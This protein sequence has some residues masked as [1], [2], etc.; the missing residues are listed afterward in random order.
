MKSTIWE[1]PPSTQCRIGVAAP[2]PAR[3][4][5]PMRFV[6]PP[7]GAIPPPPKFAPKP[8]P[9]QSADTG[10]QRPNYAYMEMPKE[11]VGTLDNLFGLKSAPLVKLK[12]QK[13]MT[14]QTPRRSSSGDMK[15]NKITCRKIDSE[16]GLEL[17]IYRRGNA[18]KSEYL[19]K[20]AASA[21][22]RSLSVNDAKWRKDP[23]RIGDAVCLLDEISRLKSKIDAAMREKQR[24]DDNMSVLQQMFCD[25]NE[26]NQMLELEIE[27]LNNEQNE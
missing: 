17:V 7:R 20:G 26:K 4:P 3:T 27:R 8:P 13:R 14:L 2:A 19:K 1:A 6:L 12:R 23:N 5:P 18:F 10:K 16:R 24:I 9:K 21:Q 15:K 22:R 25:K 11:E